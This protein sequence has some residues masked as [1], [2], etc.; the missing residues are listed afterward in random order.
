MNLHRKAL[1][2]RRVFLAAVLS[3]ASCGPLGA[4]PTQPPSVGTLS[5]AI[6]TLKHEKDAAEQYAVILSTVAKNDTVL[7]L[8]GFKLFADAK[9][10]FEGLIAELRF[11]LVNGQDL[12]TSA[13]F[14]EALKGAAE[15]RVAFTSFVSGEI[16][17]LQGARPGLPDV[18]K[19]VPELVTAISDA[20]LKIWNAYHDANKER[21]ETIMSELQHLELRSFADLA[22]P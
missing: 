10:D 9:S 4:Q 13:K 16:D 8:R 6:G 17:K 3:A 2:A 14:N 21:R 1:V 19:A 20:G 18:I 12:A 7:Y 5:E 22:K 11:D 15:E